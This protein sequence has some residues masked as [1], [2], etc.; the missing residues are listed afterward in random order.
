MKLKKKWGG[1]GLGVRLGPGWGRG[2]AGCERKSEAIV[3]IKK[4]GGGGGSGF[5]L[6]GQGGCE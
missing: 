2:Q 5:R 1:V 6:G 3:K 4:M